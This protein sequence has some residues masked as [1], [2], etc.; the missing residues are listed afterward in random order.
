MIAIFLLGFCLR[1]GE[2]LHPGPVSE[3]AEVTIGCINPTGLMHKAD[4]L[5]MLPG[6]GP[7]I[8]GVCETH[9]SQQGIVKFRDELKF[10]KSRYKFLPGAPAPLRSTSMNAIG[11]CHVGTG[12]LSN[13][14]G[15]N[16]PQDRFEAVWLEAR[17]SLS[18][19]FIQGHWIHAAV[20]YGYAF[21]A[22][23]V[24][25][26]EMTNNLMKQA[27]YRL[28]HCMTGKRILMGDFNQLDGQLDE[29]EKLKQ[30]GWK[31]T[32]LLDLERTQRPISLTCKQTSTKDFVWIS[33]ELVPWFIRADT[34]SLFSDHAVFV[35]NF[36][37]FWT[38][39]KS[40]SLAEA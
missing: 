20:V 3:Q 21:R 34:C 33:P 26:R 31:E 4:V 9:L 35:C 11:G 40:T 5:T 28:V 17:H 15:R 1:I 7:S 22:A 2:A 13:C 10:R 32:Q 23:S 19:F 29:L 27:T 18:T 14:P 39:L 30:L 25:V 38:H 24:E 8:W 6:Q 37:T 16:L 36:Q 12:F